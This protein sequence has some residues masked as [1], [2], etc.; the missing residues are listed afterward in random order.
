MK[1]ASLNDKG[2]FWGSA[3]GGAA[4]R[5]RSNIIRMLLHAGADVNVVGEGTGTALTA[6]VRAGHIEAAKML[7]DHGGNV[8]IAGDGG[9][10]PLM[11]AAGGGSEA[12]LRLLISSGVEVNADGGKY[13]NSALGGAVFHGD[14]SAVRVLRENGADLSLDVRAFRTTYK[15]A[16]AYAA[17]MNRLP[18]LE[19]LIGSDDSPGT[20]GLLGTALRAALRESESDEVVQWLL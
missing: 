11:A 9:G 2:E 20:K 14:Q 6:A 17:S 12:M 4:S 1:G 8:S 15:N 3:L 7:P 13:Y 10:H 5:G 18:I 19:S 16:V